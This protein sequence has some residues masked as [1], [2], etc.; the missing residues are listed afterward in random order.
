MK[1][2]EYIAMGSWPVLVGY[3][4]SKKAFNKLVK[5]IECND[6]NGWMATPTALATTHC[7]VDDEGVNCFI[8]TFNPDI[9]LENLPSIIAHEAWH[10]VEGIY[11][12]VG[13]DKFGSEATAYLIQYLVESMYKGLTSGRTA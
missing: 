10:I 6:H 1:K 12:Y 5:D 4:D 7:F 8:V 2:V 13:E 9:K 11:E 3:T